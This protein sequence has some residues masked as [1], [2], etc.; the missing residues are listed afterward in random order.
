[1]KSALINLSTSHITITQTPT[2][3][4]KKFLGG[5]GLGAKLLFD[6]IG[7]GVDPLSPENRLIFTT[8]L[9]TGT[10][11]PTSARLHVTFKSPLT[12]IYGYSN[13]GGFFGAELRHA[14]YDALIVT[15]RAEEPVILRVTDAGVTIEPAGDLWGRATGA[16]HDALLESGAGRV[17]CIG[18]AGENLVH[19]AAIV[20]DRSRVAARGGPGAVKGNKNL[21]AIHVR[22]GGRPPLPAALRS[23]ARRASSNDWKMQDPQIPQSIWYHTDADFVGFR[24]V[25]PLDEPSWDDPE[26]V[27]RFAELYEPDP[28]IMKEYKEAQG[29]KE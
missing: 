28:E 14:G 20:N 26:E 2:D 21:K 27:K 22:A 11:W 13:S 9:L 10:P 16:V 17:A 29:G 7:P 4:L 3:L 25:R 24:V 1:M 19:L 15:G 12:G 23:A 8:G 6:T 18:P 5:R